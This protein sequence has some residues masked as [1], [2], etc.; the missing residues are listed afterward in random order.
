[1]AIGIIGGSGVYNMEGLEDVQEQSVET[2]FGEPSD[3]YIGGKI[4]GTQVYFLPRH[5]RGHT[6]MPSEI[7]HRANIMGFK[8]LG[9]E[10]VMSVSAVGS[11]LEE[12]RPRDIVLPDQY[13]DRT[14]RSHEH[15][16]FGNGVVAHVSMAEPTCPQLRELIASSAEDVIHGHGGELD[17]RVNR[18]GT[19]INMEGPA[20]S[21]RAESNVYRQFGFDVIG[22]TS[23]GEAKL[24]REAELCY[25]SM[26]MVTDYDC[27]HEETGHVTVDMVIGHLTANSALAREVVTEVATR[28]PGERTCT[29]GSAMQAALI[30]RSPDTGTDTVKALEPIIGKYIEG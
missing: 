3:A 14:K 27:W 4:G 6:I 10:R 22:M 1:M 17:V 30:T 16:F 21:T 20:F 5:G 13:F 12:L 15:T 11:L 29:C 9:V 2:P 8:L 18:G 25:Q 28:L 19:Y 24:C 7:N 26:A 23:L